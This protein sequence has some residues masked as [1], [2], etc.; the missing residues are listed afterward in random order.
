MIKVGPSGQIAHYFIKNKLTLLFVITALILGVF[1]VIMTPREEDPQIQVPMVDIIIPMPGASPQEVERRV[2]SPMEKLMW[3]IPNVKYVYSTS[4]ANMGLVIVRF[5]VNSDEDTALVRI[6]DKVIGHMNDM[7]KGAMMPLIKLHSIN[8][9]PVLALTLWGKGY[10]AY[11]LTRLGQEL[12]VKL[13]AVP[14]TSTVTLLGAQKREVRVT[15]DP[16]R[17]AAHH[18]NPLTIAQ[19]LQAFNSRLPAGSL[20]NDNKEIRLEVGSWLKDDR[21]VASVL[22]GFFQGNRSTSATWPGSRTAPRCR[23]STSSSEWAPRPERSR[24]SPPAPG[25]SIQP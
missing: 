5:K 3:E 18:V 17:M 8:D 9:V 2:V 12:E 22:V 11:T 15:L 13:R 20:V 19:S 10:D 7:P 23:I 25:A 1:A 24:A 4:S 14:D 16:V 21:D 6:Y